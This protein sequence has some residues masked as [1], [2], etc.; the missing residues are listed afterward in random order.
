MTMEVSL[1]GN[2]WIGEEKQYSRKRQKEKTKE[3]KSE[4]KQRKR[5]AY[6]YSER[7]I[8]KKKISIQEEVSKKIDKWVYYS[9]K[10]RWSKFKVK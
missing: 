6:R 4:A 3:K 10:E 5:Q 9:V 1:W 8:K 7:N 2:S